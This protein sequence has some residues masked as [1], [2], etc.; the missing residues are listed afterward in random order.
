MVLFASESGQGAKATAQVQAGQHL[1]FYLIQKAST[2]HWRS[3]NPTNALSTGPKA[4]FSI[5]AASPDA[6]DHLHA[7]WNTDGRLSLAWEDGTNG[8]DRDYNDAIIRSSGL[9]AL[10]Q[11]FTYQARASDA[12]GDTLTYRLLDGP[13]GARIDAATGLLTWSDP[14]VGST[15]FRLEADDGKGGKTEQ[16]FTVLVQE[17]QNGSRTASVTVQSRLVPVSYTHLTLPT[18]DLV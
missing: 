2:A 16:Y 4:F 3:S 8:G 5:K 17:A 15:T 14:Q 11:T 1:G 18:S 9:A 10:T 7:T 12:D 13:P 6:Y